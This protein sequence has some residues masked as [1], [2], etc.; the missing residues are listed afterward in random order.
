MCAPY[1]PPPR[2]P[3]PLPPGS[4]L[5]PQR[6]DAEPKCSQGAASGL[7]GAV[8]TGDQG[9]EGLQVREEPHGLPGGERQGLGASN[10]GKQRPEEGWH[11]LKYTE[12]IGAARGDERDPVSWQAGAVSTTNR[13]RNSQGDTG[14]GGGNIKISERTEENRPGDETGSTET[15]RSR[16]SPP[17]E[18]G[19]FEG[20]PRG[21]EESLCSR[22]PGPPWV[23]G[24]IRAR[25]P[26]ASRGDS[27]GN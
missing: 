19:T 13:I 16:G 17:P 15:S 26:C 3:R 24:G 23:G 4:L 11:G 18:P 27:V 25:T 5:P 12:P 20:T 1:P 10:G 21:P 6:R 22:F 14:D 7:V 8:L 2:R 9:A